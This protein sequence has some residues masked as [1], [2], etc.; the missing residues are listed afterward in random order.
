[1]KSRSWDGIKL[2][3]D[4]LF[5]F[6]WSSLLTFF[7]QSNDHF[8]LNGETQKIIFV[9]NVRSLLLQYFI[10]H[11]HICIHTYIFAYEC[12]FGR[13]IYRRTI[14]PHWLISQMHM[15]AGNRSSQSQEPRTPPKF[16]RLMAETQQPKPSL[17]PPSMPINTAHPTAITLAF[18]FK[19]LVL[20][21]FILYVFSK[22]FCRSDNE[23]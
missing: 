9:L 3:L 12:V 20:Y 5:I 21:V 17:L 22:W 15:T 6:V 14:S 16:P 10:Y 4:F 7:I 19:C 18:T 1:M 8:S 23:A 11:T 13:Y 2:H